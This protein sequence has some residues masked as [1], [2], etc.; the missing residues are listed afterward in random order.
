MSTISLLSVG[1]RLIRRRDTQEDVPFRDSLNGTDL[2]RGMLSRRVIQSKCFV[3]LKTCPL[4]SGQGLPPILLVL[5]QTC[6]TIWGFHSR[7]KSA[8]RTPSVWRSHHWETIRMNR[9][10]EAGTDEA[11][12][13]SCCFLF[14]F[15][16][17]L[18]LPLASGVLEGDSGPSTFSAPGSVSSVASAAE[19]DSVSGPTKQLKKCAIAPP[20]SWSSVSRRTPWKKNHTPSLRT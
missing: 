16:A 4:L 11:A 2:Q 15:F 1:L 19:S 13:L 10:T 5:H 17:L 8:H 6:A 20:T 3:L 18:T 9:R 14:F 12:F 7:T